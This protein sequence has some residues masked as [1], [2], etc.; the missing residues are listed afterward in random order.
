MKPLQAGTARLSKGCPAWLRPGWA[1]HLQQGLVLISSHRKR[2]A[3]MLSA[4]CF[5]CST[6]LPTV[7]YQTNTVTYQF[8]AR[9]EFYK[10]LSRQTLC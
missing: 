10:F 1:A 7:T 4:C 9:T 5:C 6:A 8:S 3:S 2:N